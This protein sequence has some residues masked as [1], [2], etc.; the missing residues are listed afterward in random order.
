LHEDYQMIFHS[1]G[2][3]LRLED[4]DMDRTATL[5]WTSTTSFRINGE[6]DTFFESE[7]V[8]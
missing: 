7:K 6:P 5:T 8:I 4:F 1:P 3:T 2:K